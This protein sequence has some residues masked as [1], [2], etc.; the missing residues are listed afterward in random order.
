MVGGAF[1]LAATNKWI[2]PLTGYSWRLTFAFY[3]MMVLAIA[4]RL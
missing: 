2:M 4:F 1:A 3:G